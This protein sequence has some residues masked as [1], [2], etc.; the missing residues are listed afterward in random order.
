M[1]WSN[2]GFTQFLLVSDMSPSNV[3]YQS[4]G[5]VIFHCLSEDS[6]NI[7]IHF[8]YAFKLNNVAQFRSQQSNETTRT[9]KM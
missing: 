5:I 1:N 8:H 6:V 7:E 2:V 4:K 3:E 9:V